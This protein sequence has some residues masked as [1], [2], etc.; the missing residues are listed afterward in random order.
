VAIEK[1]SDVLK[2][3]HRLIEKV[4]AVLESFAE[5]PAAGSFDAWE[6]TLEFIREF[7]DRCHH[8]KEERILFPA[9]ES[10]GIS[11]AGG[12]LGV[13]L[14]EHE[15]GRAHV[16]AMREALERWANGEE[17]A[18]A[19]MSE[20]ASAYLRLLREH[21][22]K[23]DDVLFVMADEALTDAE[24]KKLVDE[25]EKHELEE[26]GAGIHE[27]YSAIARELVGNRDN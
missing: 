8:L 4:L 10:H 26:M 17:A 6:K 20:N 15:Q 16:G 13:M 3:E 21:I 19:V 5:D 14:E 2:H 24:Q 7:A 18:K 1:V 23:E 22:R 25:F 12:P 11:T 9:L 27:K